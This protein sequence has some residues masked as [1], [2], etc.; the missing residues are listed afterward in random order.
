MF[1]RIMSNQ[2]KQ[3]IIVCSTLRTCKVSISAFFQFCNYKVEGPLHC[4]INFVFYKIKIS[5]FITLFDI[6]H[7]TLVHRSPRRWTGEKKIPA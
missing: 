1:S 6:L 5:K 2:V 4:K 3:L 7:K